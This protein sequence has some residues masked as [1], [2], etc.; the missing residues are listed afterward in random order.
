MKFDVGNV[1]V[2]PTASEVLKD[3][4]L[5]MEKLL[6][7]HQSGDW[8]DVSDQVRQINELGLQRP[9]NLQSAY[10]TPAGQRV[11]FVTMADRSVTLVHLDQQVGAAAAR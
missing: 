2:T 3:S 5:T 11:T 6:A 7:R 4:G 8:G 1:I 9:L 10:T